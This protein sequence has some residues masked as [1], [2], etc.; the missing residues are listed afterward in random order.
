MK[1]NRA[2]EKKG[3]KAAL[4][5]SVGA[6]S[7]LSVRRR[8]IFRWV[9]GFVLPVLLLLGIE[10]GL[11]LVGWGYPTHFFVRAATGPPGTFVENQRFGYRFFP[12][13]LAR[14][15]DPIRLSIAKPPGTCRVFVFGESAALGDPVPA[16]GFSRILRE[17][18]EGRRP[19]TK[20]EV[21]NTGM[22]AINSHAIL[23]ITRD[24]VPFQGDIWIL[25]MGNNE[26]VGPFG[27]ASVFGLKSPPMALIQAG[28]AI[29]RTRLGQLLDSLWQHA[30]GHS[31]QFTQWEGM[32]MMV[33][34]Q[35][36]ADDPKLQRV[37]DDFRSNFSGIL[38]AA[39]RAG[40]K[41]IVCSVSSNLKDC[42][43]FASVNQRA[44]PEARQAEWQ[45]ALTAG[46]ELERQQNYEHALAQYARAAELDGSSAEL[47][48]RM[49]RCLLDLGDVVKAREQYAQARDLDA[50]RFRAD[51]RMNAILR[52]VCSSRKQA[53]VQFFDSEAT[54]TNACK[55]GIPG[56]ECFWDHVHF[57][58]DGN[59][60]LARG[61][62]DEVLQLFPEPQRASV[63]AN[64]KTLTEAECGERLAYT[65]FDQRAVLEEMLKRVHDP[66]FTGQLDHDRLVE[67]WLALKA[68]L[69][70]RNDSAGLSNAVAIYRRA[71][72]RRPGDWVLHH[73]FGALLNATGDLASAEQQ[74]RRVT[75]LV[76]DYVDAWFKL[77]DV[78]MRQGRLADA[79]ADYRRV[80]QL[81]PS[82]FEAMNGLGL[83]LGQEG[84]T[85]EA[86]RLFK[87]AL[88]VEPEFAEVHVNWGLLLFRHG[89][90]PEAEDHYRK[91]LAFDPQSAAAR[92]N[93][94]NLLAS[95]QKYA[96]AIE[97]YHQA[98]NLKPDDATV[99]FALANC[100]GAMGQEAEAVAQYREAL[101]ANPSFADAQFNLGVALA[102]RGDLQGAAACFEQAV[103][104]NPND[105]Q[106]RLNLGVALAQQGRFDEAITQF[107][108]TLELDPANAAAR[109]YLEIAT[110][111]RKGF[112]Q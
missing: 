9:A 6:P 23:P 14:A 2:K 7:T 79:Q 78:S 28:L 38:S 97:Q 21:I 5:P 51:S 43:P 65:D 100:L 90:V 70:A 3:A 62:A 85:D 105:P 33:H 29:K 50:L 101:R 12:H 84:K 57:N 34:E 56:Q 17:L 71:L 106:G 1:T 83:V 69:D 96:E 88:K 10:L 37:Y 94:G 15:P 24:C 111:K 74:W 26:V 87:D 20:F 49:A 89:Q 64:A 36:R 48:F 93:L 112:Q 18:L 109:R 39:K 13:R 103:R 82:S 72:A 8:R 86:I 60:R 42:P 40:V 92:I 110:R 80:L 19:G 31:R 59:Y 61:L 52:E 58:F 104:L 4:L 67:Q 11:R 95:Q 32:K 66:P 22:T 102:K 98:L 41:T 46:V 68:Q 25:Y 47:R 53:N 63:Q 45:R 81:R 108:A 99:H 54:L 35:V 16:Y 77:G 73:R 44:L 55:G 76:P 75:E 107:Q 27:A 30:P 91:A